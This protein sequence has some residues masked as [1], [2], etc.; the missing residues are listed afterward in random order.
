MACGILGLR[1]G[2]KPM[3]TAVEECSLN[4]WITREIPPLAILTILSATELSQASGPYLES[5]YQ[6]PLGRELSLFSWV[7]N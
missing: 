3:P 6:V 1:P 2:T 4:H 5:F 7:A